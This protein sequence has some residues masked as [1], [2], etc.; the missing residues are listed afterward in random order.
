MMFRR[1][2][3]L[4]KGNPTLYFLGK[5]EESVSAESGDSEHAGRDSILS[6]VSGT[7]NPDK[8][9]RIAKSSL[10]RRVTRSA[11]CAWNLDVR[12][13]HDQIYCTFCHGSEGDLL[14]DY[15]QE[16]VLER[17]GSLLAEAMFSVQSNK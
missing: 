11:G 16:P 3:R 8:W 7:I 14:V 13:R 2:Q 4:R 5:S 12:I 6:R 15:L 9:Y 10:N 1:M 17:C